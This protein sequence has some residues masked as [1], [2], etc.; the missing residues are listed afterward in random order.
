MEPRPEPWFCFLWVDVMPMERTQVRRV[1]FL[2]LAGV[3]VQGEGTAS[4]HMAATCRRVAVRREHGRESWHGRMG[5]HLSFSASPSVAGCCIP[6][7]TSSSVA[8]MGPQSHGQT[9]DGWFVPFDE[10][11]R[12]L[13]CPNISGPS[14]M[15]FVY[16]S[17]K[18]FVLSKAQVTTFI[19]WAIACVIRAV[20]LATWSFLNCFFRCSLLYRLLFLCTKQA[21]TVGSEGAIP[22]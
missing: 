21:D 10:K 19:C 3:K 17:D 16:R 20:N 6:T 1:F 22:E 14:L 11:A 12:P 13:F 15:W 18:I 5:E 2:C 4:G 9:M 7:A 8:S